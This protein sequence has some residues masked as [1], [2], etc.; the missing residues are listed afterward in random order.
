MD[1][2]TM[3]SGRDE[4]LATCLT[5]GLVESPPHVLTV[6]LTHFDYTIR[7]KTLLDEVAARFGN[8]LMRELPPE[9]RAIVERGEEQTP[10]DIALATRMRA[11]QRDALMT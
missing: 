2:E 6:Y 9:H 11:V 3:V 8:G 1:K 7:H 5:T 10:E 4:T